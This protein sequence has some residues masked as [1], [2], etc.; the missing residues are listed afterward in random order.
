MCAVTPPAEIRLPTTMQAPAAARALPAWCAAAPRTT[1]EALDE[2]ELLVSEL[3]TNA[4]LHGTPPVQR[5]GGVSTAAEACWCPSR[6][7]VAAHPAEARQQVREDDS[8]RGM[9]LVD[10]ISDRWGVQ[11]RPGTGKAVWFQLRH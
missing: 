4:V 5:A 8:G 10:V 3:A 7:V 9:L 1:P 6:T 11:T 2:A